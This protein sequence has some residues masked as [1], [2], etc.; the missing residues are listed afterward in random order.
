MMTD[1]EK[2]EV[3][4]L[5]EICERL[6]VP[7]PTCEGGAVV[8]RQVNGIALPCPAC[9]RGRVSKDAETVKRL[10]ELWRQHE[11]VLDTDLNIRFCVVCGASQAKGH[12]ADCDLAA[13]LRDVD[14]EPE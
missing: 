7:C 6:T 1:T 10:R 13:A 2:Q 11:W 5:K 4:A 8:V 3:Q 9:V 14:K 12:D